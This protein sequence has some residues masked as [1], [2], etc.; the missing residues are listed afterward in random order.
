MSKQTKR[1]QGEAAER[2]FTPLTASRLQLR[3]KRENQPTAIE[4]YGAV[5]YRAG[6]AGTEYQLWR[7]GYERIART[8]FDRAIAEDDV[9]SLF[10]HDSN[11]VL[12]RN[13]ADPPTLVLS[14]DEVGLKYSVTPPDTQMVRDLVMEPIRRGDVS[15]SS[16][17]FWPRKVTWIEEDRDGRMVEIRQIDEVLLVEVG[18]VTFPAYA[19]TTSGVR[20]A[21]PGDVARVRAERDAWWRTWDD[22]AEEV[23]VRLRMMALGQ[24]A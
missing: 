4:G 13:A 7:D 11:F 16:F 17:M 10:N 6:D 12:G 14:V 22:E 15:G 18:P 8:A 21:D 19:G 9:R 1:D 3:E 2:R 20:A 5:F 24:A 23:A